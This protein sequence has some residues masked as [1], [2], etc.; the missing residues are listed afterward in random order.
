MYI[1]FFG[2]YKNIGFWGV[3]VYLIQG[4]WF[5]YILWAISLYMAFQ[6]YTN[7]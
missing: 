5:T 3:Y 6:L 1:C 7:S 2:G 4:L